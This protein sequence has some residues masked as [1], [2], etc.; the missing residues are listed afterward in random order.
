M[1]REIID[2]LNELL[3]AE[4]AG[5]ELATKLGAVAS[6]GYVEGELKKFSEDEAWASIGLWRAILRYG[7]KPSERTGDFV[8][9]VLA[10]PTEGE[11]LKLLAR[12]QAWVVKRIDALLEMGLDPETT[13]FLTEMREEH[14]ENIDACNRRADE[15]PAPPSPPY[16]DLPFARLREAHDQVFYGAW[17][18]PK[19]TVRDLQR[20]YHQ[21]GRYLDM[22]AREVERSRSKEAKT[23][24][25]KAREAYDQIDL[26]GYPEGT[27]IQLDSVL[28]YC[29]RTLDG[30]LQQYRVPAH[31]P[32]HLEA[33]Y[34]TRNVPFR[35]LYGDIVEWL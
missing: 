9:K 31:D 20:A 10:L 7:G 30:L 15:L 19:A 6:K 33:Y 2:R 14:L 3:E 13:A 18:A 25:A 32:R 11:Q 17:R 4:R 8:Q 21:L 12:G 35:E 28:A 24:L 26:E 29:H 5:V 34:D 22:L 16:R 23:F 27:S 1:S